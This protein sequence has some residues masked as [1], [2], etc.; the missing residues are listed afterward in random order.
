MNMRL[1]HFFHTMPL[2]KYKILLWLHIKGLQTERKGIRTLLFWAVTQHRLVVSYR[3][4]WKTYQFHLQGSSSPLKMGLIG[5]LKMLVIAY[6]S[7]LHNI[8]EE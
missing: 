3:H 4:F 7:T 8:L 6:Q 5:C 2:L 1:H